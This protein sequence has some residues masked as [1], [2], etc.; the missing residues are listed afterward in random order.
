MGARPEPAEI[1]EATSKLQYHPCM[2]RAVGQAKTGSGVGSGRRR[3]HG[4]STGEL[5]QA[6]GVDGHYHN[7]GYAD[8]D[9]EAVANMAASL[10]AREDFGQP[11]TP[12][13]WD[14]P[15]FHYPEGTPAQQAQYFAVGNA[16]NFRFWERHDEGVLTRSEGTI[17][18]ER[19]GGAMYMWRALRRSLDRGLPV[20]DAAYL[21]NLNAAE[22]DAI[23]ADDDG[24]N[25]LAVGAG[26]RIANLRDLGATLQAKYDGQFMGVAQ[27]ARGSL[28]EF[29]RLS[30]QFRA[31]DDPVFKLSSLNAIM[32]H[33]SGVSTF[34][35]AALPAIDYHLV[36]H[37]LRQG[38]VTPAPKI[39]AKLIAGELL[40]ATEGQALRDASLDAYL[41]LS[42]Q[43]G[44]SG[45]VLDNKYW[46]N[47]K[48][49]GDPAVCE[50]PETAAQCPFIDRCP[51]HVEYG[52]PL[53]LTRYY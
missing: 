42:E 7:S 50:N 39:A 53:E 12:A 10:R 14:D 35:D 17:D 37:A 26:E 21:A 52:L 3:G 33:D 9:A 29:A 40:S 8:V 24:N 5:A 32:L 13:K 16:I 38:M 48:N 30:E 2:G 49:C 23:F 47:R 43:T 41:R 28:V 44:L 4:L 22:F 25:P 6:L 31:W 18:G 11:H 36:R 34:S 20:L 15:K 27:A 1:R 51:R 46:F 45:A 19:F